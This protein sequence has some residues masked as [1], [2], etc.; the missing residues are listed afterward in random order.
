MDN[1][2][3][4][5]LV[6]PETLLEALNQCAHY[7]GSTRHETALRLLIEGVRARYGIELNLDGSVK[8]RERRH[9]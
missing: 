2:R 7:E 6:L 9:A 1:P 3:P 8:H 4:T 5:I